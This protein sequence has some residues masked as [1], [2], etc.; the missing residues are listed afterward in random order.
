MIAKIA[1]GCLLRKETEN[2]HLIIGGT[3]KRPDLMFAVCGNGAV[4]SG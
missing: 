3:F 4:F 2:C 1:A